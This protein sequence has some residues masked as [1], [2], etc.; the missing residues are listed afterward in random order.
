MTKGKAPTQLITV[1]YYYY[2][3]PPPPQLLSSSTYHTIVPSFL[4]GV[5]GG[6]LYLR[7]APVSHELGGGSKLFSS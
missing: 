2:A 3:P 7:E 4:Q 5:G 1:P 6:G